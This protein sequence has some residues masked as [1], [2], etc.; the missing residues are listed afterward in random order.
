MSQQEI[1]NQDIEPIVVPSYLEQ[2]DKKKKQKPAVLGK[3]I[4]KWKR[5]KT[6]ED[7]REE[8]K[9]KREG[10]VL[11]QTPYVVPFLQIQ[12][13]VIYLKEGVMDILQIEPSDLQSLN[14]TDLNILL[15]A[16][17]RFLRS[18]FYDY[19][20]VTLNFPANMERQ[21]RYWLKKRKKTTDPLRLRFIDRKLFEFDFLEKERTNREFFLFLYADNKQ[22]L[23][24]RK[25]V[26]IRGMKQSFPIK[27]ISQE[28]KEDILFLL[29]NQN[30]KL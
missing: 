21:K 5:K 10:K 20:E 23:D 15:L 29:N 28:K 18:Y 4:R 12:E 11:S 6:K 14:D 27:K 19:K 25:D 16:Q 30:T 7:Q 1:E 24:E 9:R 3:A 26:V 22:Q 2:E 17:T 8:V 13:D